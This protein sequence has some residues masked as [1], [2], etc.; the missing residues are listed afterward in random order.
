MVFGL[1]T[2]GLLQ[3]KLLMKE[4]KLLIKNK[5]AGFLGSVVIG[6]AIAVVGPC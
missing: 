4:H 3:P 6:L 2:T 1:I 5:P